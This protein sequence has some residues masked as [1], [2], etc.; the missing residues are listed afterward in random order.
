MS[1]S[2][3][4]AS[5]AVGIVVVVVGG[6]VVVV[7]VVDVVVGAGVVVV[8]AGAAGA[9]VAAAA[10]VGTLSVVSPQEAMRATMAMA[11][12][13]DDGRRVGGVPLWVSGPL[14]RL[15]D[16]TYC[17]RER[18]AWCFLDG[19]VNKGSAPPR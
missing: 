6:A 7:V 12:R 4:T 1:P 16:R 17:L 11:V 14:R 2:Q 3:V 19:G 10:V 8:S 15:P 13:S 5:F 9:V 18:L